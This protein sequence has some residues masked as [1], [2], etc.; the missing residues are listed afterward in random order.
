MIVIYDSKETSFSSLGLG[1]LKD[2]KSNPLIT[3]E[4][5][6]SFILEFDY[7]K[8]GFL[9][10]K[11]VEGNLIKTNH[12]IFR[13]KSI[14]KSMS[15]SDKISILAQQ[16][17][18]YDMSSNFLEDVAPT[19]LN[20]QS[21]ISWLL[22]K[23]KTSNNFEVNGDC[24]FSSSARYVR[25]NVID[26]IYTADNC[27]FKRFGGE[28]EFKLNKV[29]IHSKRGKDNGFSIRKRKNLKGIEF[30]LDFS[31]VVTK[32]LP[33]GNDELLLD[34]LYVVSSKL[35]D[36]YQPFYKKIDFNI[37][38]DE[39]TTEV[40]AKEKLKSAAEK[41]F[42]T[43][44]DIPEISIKIDFIEL[45]KCVEY[46]KY[47]NLETC[48]LGDTVKVIVPEFNINTSVRVVKT[49]FDVLLN[50]FVQLEL[51]TIKKNIV[52]SQKDTINNIKNTLE[53]P[54]SILSMAKNQASDIINHPF[55]GNL[56]IDKTNGRL[57]LMDTKDPKTAKNVWQWS[58]GGLGYSKNGINGP[59]D[60]AITQDGKIVADFITT[61]KLNTNVIE[62]YESLITTVKSIKNLTD[63]IKTKQETSS[64]ELLKTP[65]STG[66][67]NKLSIKNFNLQTLYP[68]M[69]YPS[70]YTYPGVLNFY[71]LIISNEKVVYSPSLPT[72]NNQTELYNVGG[73]SGKFYRC[74]DNVW[75]EET[76]LDNI[77]FIYINSPFPLQTLTTTMGDHVYDELIFEDNQ[78]SI[79]QRLDYDE[80]NNLEVLE[81]PVTYNLGEMLVPTFETNTYITM[82]YWTNL[83][84]ECTYIEKNEF[85]SSFTTK[86]ETNALISITNEI[87]LKVENKCG[88][89]DVVNQL[90][91]SK[92]LIEIKG[93]R[94]VLDADNIK[95]DKFGNILLSNGAK[96]LGEYGLLSSI[97]V[98]S[99]IMSRSFI[100]GNM[101]LPMGYS[102]YEE[103]SSGSIT[104]IKDSLQ[105]QF[106]IPKGFKIMSAFILLE[107]MPTKY[108]DGTTLKYTGTSK[109]LKL[110]RATN[111]SAGTFVMDITRYVTNNS[112]INYSE[113][114]NAFGV[115]GFSG[116]SSG[117]TSKQSI[118]I[119][120]FITTSDTEDSFNMFKIETSNSLVTSLAAM[121]QNTGACKATL[122][123]M[124]YSSFE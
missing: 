51:G 53:N 10:D 79:I 33:Q 1:I 124:G 45:S 29:F 61:G 66:A 115:S 109:N 47:K 40:E 21:A 111:Y 20:A 50:R 83:N 25:K 85:T 108:K 52:T 93:N 49:V 106:T 71:T 2:F 35:N 84:Y 67:I 6:G 60:L 102:Q 120:D 80:E 101:I 103:T 7:A 100:G 59:Y 44:I 56:F 99:N 107:H 110:Y 14:T 64:I 90:N 38:M 62:G 4:L 116:S 89:D 12:Q 73:I 23:A 77:K 42:E 63:Y 24:T 75:T 68:D 118:N 16:Y 72:A 105:L 95:I 76:K 123:I 122:M 32:I 81:K 15:D 43:G 114:P 87:N 28:P 54:T 121:Y 97:I 36:Y 37:G 113:V 98:E 41:L 5:K 30:N 48:S 3:E 57:Y 13:I 46:E 31:T 74:V 55:G 86:N 119:K 104:T 22:S 9:S 27:I 65:D 58:L 19:N 78:V 39:E 18:Q 8:E 117:Y 70:D 17:F 26:A 91:I 92:D 96:V 94:F 112:E 11:L 69:A 88:K 82:K 34:D